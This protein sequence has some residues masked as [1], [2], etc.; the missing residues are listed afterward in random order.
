MVQRVSEAKLVQLTR[1]QAEA[2]GQTVHKERFIFLYD[3]VLSL[4]DSGPVCSSSVLRYGQKCYIA[5]RTG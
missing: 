4:I 5:N 3:L 2:S 1:K